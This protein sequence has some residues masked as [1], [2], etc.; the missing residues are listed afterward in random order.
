MKTLGALLLLAL[1]YTVGVERLFLALDT[2]DLALK[3]AYERAAAES[4]A[5]EPRRAHPVP[6]KDHYEQR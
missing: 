6:M 3:N 4:S 2:A 5:R 1:A